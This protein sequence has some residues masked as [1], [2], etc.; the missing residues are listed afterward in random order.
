MYDVKIL[1]PLNFDIYKPTPFWEKNIVDYLENL[2]IVNFLYHENRSEN[3]FKIDDFINLM[4]NELNIYS[5]NR[6]NNN[7]QIEYVSKIIGLILSNDDYNSFFK[8][9]HPK[10]RDIIGNLLNIVC[11]I[12]YSYKFND[13][14][15]EKIYIKTIIDILF[16]INKR[17][18]NNQK[19]VDK[20][21]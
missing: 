6:G 14:A 15:D 5:F 7:L 8:V 17:L 3:M 13:Q 4:N 19:I 20:K 11:L 2:D 21:K 18:I 10:T 1:F 16:D 9:I 12:K